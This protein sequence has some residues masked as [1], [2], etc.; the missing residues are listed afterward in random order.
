LRYFTNNGYLYIANNAHF[1]DDTATNYATFVNRGTIIA[2]SQTINSADLEIYG[3]SQS[4]SGDFTATMQTGT[5]SNASI[6]SAGAIQLFANT[7]RMNRSFFAAAGALNLSVTN[8]LTDN[9]FGFGNVFNCKSGFN[10]LV[11]PATGD[12]LGST[13]QTTAAARAVVT[14]TWAGQDLGPTAA[15]FSNNAA[16]GSL[17]F[18]AGGSG[19]FQEPEFI[20]SGTGASNGLY[21]VYLD[22]SQLTNYSF[23]A[24][25]VSISPN[26][27]I[28]FGSAST[29]NLAAL[30]NAFGG[31]LVYVP[32]VAGQFASQNTK[33]SAGSYNSNNHTFQF[34]ITSL[35]G[36]TNVIQASTNLINWVP[37]YTN[38][39]SFTYTNSY[40]TNSPVLFFRGQIPGL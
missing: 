11:K 14:H 29:T 15:G 16:I 24:S 21:V 35:S 38:I 9:G 23:D 17:V 10:L 26:L 37:I 30:T 25:L 34:S 28:Y 36:Q 5:I 19:S 22:I 1:G 3:T 18:A 32:G 7:L 39:G 40:A 27:T 20:F 13:F 2:G 12:L 31:R 8:S 33:L 4:T 6:S